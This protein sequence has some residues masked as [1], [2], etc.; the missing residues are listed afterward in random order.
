MRAKN[1]QRLRIVYYYL[2][3]A[4]NL[5]CQH[6]YV[7]EHLPKAKHAD[8][9]RVIHNIKEYLTHGAKEIVFLGGEP[10]LHPRYFDILQSAASIGYEHIIVDTNGVLRYPVPLGSWTQEKLT[11]R[12][13]FEGCDAA[14]HEIIRGK[15]TFK[16]ALDTL[17]RVIHQ[18]I[19]T[20]VTLTINAV[21]ISQLSEMVSFFEREGVEGLN[22]HFVSLMGNG[23][24]HP[25]LKLSA[26][27]I[28]SAQDQLITLNSSHDLPIRFPR[29]LQSRE[30]IPLNHWNFADHC[31]LFNQDVLLVFPEGQICRCPLQITLNFNSPETTQFPPSSDQCPFA[32]YL[33]PDG[34]PE[35]YEMTCI[36]WKGN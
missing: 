19:R 25:E 1:L 11:I 23:K 20:E 7:G 32:N 5:D 18:Q 34:I 9:D 21:N 22:F 13:G 29:L 15:Q 24:H 17:R 2:T 35:A 3:F 27:Q 30:K 33:I 10:T 16:S 28:L 12:I 14:T 8:Y 36:S 26:K 4:C 6:C 31:R